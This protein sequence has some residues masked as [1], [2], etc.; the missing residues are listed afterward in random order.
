L[1]SGNQAAETLLQLTSGEAGIL[2]IIQEGCG[3]QNNVDD[4][5]FTDAD[6]AVI[7]VKV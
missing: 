4:V 5:F 7:L 3:S 1:I 6:E 2:R